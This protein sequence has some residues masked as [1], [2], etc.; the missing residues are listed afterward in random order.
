M[1]PNIVHI[2]RAYDYYVR[3]WS[4]GIVKSRDRNANKIL[5]KTSRSNFVAVKLCIGY[6]IRNFV[7]T[8]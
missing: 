2:D 5:D 4:N 1:R 7:D 8:M 6:I 3:I